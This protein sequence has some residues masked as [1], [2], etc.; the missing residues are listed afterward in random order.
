MS[1]ANGRGLARLDNVGPQGAEEE[2]AELEED[3]VA[4]P[5]DMWV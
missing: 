2:E 4:G 1:W 5:A 3:G